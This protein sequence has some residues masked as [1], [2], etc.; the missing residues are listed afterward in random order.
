MKIGF[1]PKSYN[2]V[3]CFEVD[4]EEKDSIIDGLFH[5]ISASPEYELDFVVTITSKKINEVE[6]DQNS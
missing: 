1:K 6:K 5:T 4:D 3:I 2:D